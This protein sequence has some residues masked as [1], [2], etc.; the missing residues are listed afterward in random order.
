MLIFTHLCRAVAVLGIL[1][2][3]FMFW[4]AFARYY[5][6]ADQAVAIAEGDRNLSLGLAVLFGSILLGTLAEI[7]FSLRKKQDN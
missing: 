4:G 3:A 5:N 2:S 7:S 6:I 1:F